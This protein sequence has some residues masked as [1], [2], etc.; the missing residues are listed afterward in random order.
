MPS[1]AKPRIAVCLEYP[2]LEFGG[3]EVLVAELV[4]GL[5]AE[6]AITLVSRDDSLA[7]SDLPAHVAGHLPWPMAGDGDELARRLCE[8]RVELVHFHFGANFA[9]GNRR[10]GATPVLRVAAA[11]VRCLSTNHGFFSPLEGY[12]AQY[13]PLWMKLALFPAAWL[14]KAQTLA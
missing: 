4:R 6:F 11:G 12:C 9:W 2:I 5:S 14:A 10:L 13:R 1:P 7:G 3:T 8:A